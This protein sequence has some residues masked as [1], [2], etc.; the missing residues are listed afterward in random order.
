MAESTGGSGHVALIE[1]PAGCGKSELIATFADQA[2]AQ[3]A[4]V[5]SAAGWVSDRDVPF[6]TLRRLSSKSPSQTLFGLLEG[7]GVSSSDTAGVLAELLETGSGTPLVCC[8]DDLHYADA[9]TLKSLQHLVRFGR[10]APVLLVL[11]QANHFALQDSDFSTELLRMRNVRYI[12]LSRLGR[13]QVT[14]V[15]RCYPD[16]AAQAADH[17]VGLAKASGGNPLLLRALIAE[18]RNSAAGV[19]TIGGPFSQALVTCVRRSGRDGLRL[20]A[21]VAVLGEQASAS[22]LADLLDITTSAAAQGLAA[23]VASGVVNGTTFRHPVGRAAVLDYLSRKEIAV[24]HR[25]IAELLH[26][27]GATQH[28]VAQHLIASFSDRVVKTEEPWVVEVLCATAE[29]ALSSD[30][31]ERAVRLLE[32]AH[33]VS[34]DPLRRGEIK[35]R[36]AAITGRV[37]PTLSEQHLNDAFETLS[38]ADATAQSLW[39]LAQLLVAQGRIT[40]AIEIR[41]RT[42]SA[43]DAIDL[44]ADAPW[45]RNT[46][47]PFRGDDTDGGDPQFA[48]MIEANQFTAIDASIVDIERFL[49]STSLAGP[50]LS[51]IT[52]AITALT[53]SEDPQRAARWSR[54]LLEESMARRARGWQCVF[55]SA[56]AY[57]LLR[58]G[59]LREAERHALAALELIPD[60]RRCTFSCT[61]VATLI[62]ARTEM[63]DLA[64]AAAEVD[65]PV[66][67][68]LFHSVHGLSYL[69]ARGRY[70]AATN[71]LPAALE[72][73][74]EA[75]RIMKSWNLDRPI[76]LPWRT[77]AAEVLRRL[78]ETQAVDRLVLQQLSTP[79]ARHPWIRGITLRLRAATSAPKKRSLLLQQAVGEFRKSGD[80]VELAR[81]LG[82]LGEA[83]QEV[84][85]PL[86][87]VMSHQAISLATDCGA[88]SLLE[89]IRHRSPSL[90]CLEPEAA[91]VADTANAL[92]TRLSESER[93][94]A[95]LAALK[96]TNREISKLLHVTVST[97]EQHLTNVYRKLQINGRRHLPA[98]LD[99][100]A[101]DTA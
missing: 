91:G 40:D 74:F 96:Y 46:A 17:A 76:I 90:R 22:R 23:L 98:N 2:A 60:R 73:F 34:P 71:Q 54:V 101:V 36:L 41:N 4:V 52:Q 20:A 31:T 87:G 44:A 70:L 61:A 89:E 30:D 67:A 28:L 100:Y 15:V 95:A 97:V 64:G 6:S 11:S 57:A 48:S 37:D 65:Q 55:T 32:H 24:L 45:A 9:S 1:G 68:K 27:T 51:A 84:E 77:E 94:V 88:D 18:Q 72:D 93:R 82:E 83:L 8:V 81:T 19:P 14:G 69:R 26:S 59:D 47:G 53:L 62:S 78:G 16:L 43:I 35:T 56:L 75:G 92:H 3:G 79:D 63:R 29:Q 80:R 86:A 39:P 38:A 10:T 21:A 99:L 5:L 49:A 58:I 42:M 7:T 85:D 25:R 13:D 50:T 12:Q 66:P 33:A